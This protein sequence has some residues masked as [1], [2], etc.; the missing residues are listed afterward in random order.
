MTADNVHRLSVDDEVAVLRLYAEYNHAIDAGE[1]AR[2]VATW[3]DDG[4]FEHP[5]RIYR[6]TEDLREFVTARTAGLATHHLR[7]QKH[8]NSDIVLEAEGNGAVGACELLV[9]GT[10]RDTEE[11]VIAAQG[12]YTDLLRKVDDRWLFCRRK[13]T[14]V[15]T[16]RI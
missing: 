15:Q 13:L 9:V 1:V 14:L 7:S 5:A 4:L 11:T 16:S 12:Q 6:G 10:L 3:T 2:W 8:W